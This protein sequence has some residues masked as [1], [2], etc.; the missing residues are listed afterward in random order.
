MAQAVSAT[1][2]EQ[3]GM[4][5]FRRLRKRL[6]NQ[7]GHAEAEPSREFS[8]TQVDLPAKHAAAIRQ[9]AATIPDA[10]LAEDGREDAPH[11]TVKFGLHTNDVD[12]VR[13]VLADEPPITV[14]LGKTS[15]FPAKE[16]AA[17]DVVKVDVDSP[18]LHRLNAKIAKGLD[19]TDT[20]PTYKPHATLAYV[21]PG[22]GQKY[23]G[24]ADLDGRTMTLDAIVFSGKDRQT[25]SIPLTGRRVSK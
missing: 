25:V 19:H 7:P 3:N 16:G 4:D 21:K 12:D 10:D 23:V 6:A 8:S 5:A 18:D 22:L 15:I 1:S 20:H 11:I 14:T 2:R 13:R 24:R 17:Y 9:M